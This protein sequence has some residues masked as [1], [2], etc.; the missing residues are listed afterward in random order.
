MADPLRFGAVILAAGA[1][2]R[3]GTPKQL[4]PIGGTSLLRRVVDAVLAS[5]A[6]PVVIVLGAHAELIRP[7][8]VRLPVLL[9]DNASWEEGLTSS[10][11]AGIGV[12][13]SF[14]LALDAALLV[15]GDQPGLSP[16]ALRRL[17][18]THGQSGE[19]IV[20]AHYGGHPGP[21][22]LFA[23]SHFPELLEL[24]GLGG[25]RPLLARHADRVATVDLPELAVDLDTPEDYRTFL[26][27]HPAPTGIQP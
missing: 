14:S 27:R 21:P 7:Q 2:T 20:A 8:V 23:R 5:P 15:L 24:R 11:R 25:A 12:L 10:I 3:M 17:V 26:A 13:E 22:A 1:S 19:S 16:G 9:V 6:W 4:L 18:A